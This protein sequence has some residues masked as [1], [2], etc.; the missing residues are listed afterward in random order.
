MRLFARALA[1]VSLALLAACATRPVAPPQA[2]TPV[3]P[4]RPTPA[5]TPTP[6]PSPVGV[7][8]V[9]TGVRAETPRVLKADEAAT[10]LNAFRTSCLA[11]THRTDQSGLT[12]GS[13]WQGVCAQAASLDPSYAPGFF[14]YGFD[15][16]KVGDG[17]AFATGYYEPE[18]EGSRT[19]LPGYVPIYRVPP[20]LVR[21][22]QPTGQ[23][24]RGRIDPATG[25]CTLYY[26]RAEIEDGALAN[27]GLELAWAKDPVD[28]FFLEIQGSGRI[29]FPDG[30]VMRVG[31]AGQNGRDYVAIGRLLRDR[32]ILPSGGANME[33]IKAWIRA[34]PDQGRELMRENLS[35]VFFKELTGS[36]PLGA[37]NVA[38]TPHATVAA[39]PNYVPLGAPVFLNMDR[40]E[41]DGVWVAQD[42]GGAIK[43]PNRFDTF[44]GAG[45]EA[46]AIAGGMSASG[47]ALILVPKGV[48]ARAIAQP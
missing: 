33:A 30:S 27:K 14:Y 24:G 20:D 7:N 47:E 39:D 36:G 4:P 31:Y 11:V 3:P 37:L 10:A 17:R 9:A 42:T 48:A 46:V 45:P 19:P 21:C 40:Q 18:I 38:V 23:T 41:A 26:T 6:P 2:P 44:W 5:P 32:G 28:L 1:A 22:T 12:Q 43:G 29:R 15:W 16:V 25:S 34:N 8:A 35:Y 13:D